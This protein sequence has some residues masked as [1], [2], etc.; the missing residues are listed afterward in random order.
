[1]PP[2]VAP[3][4]NRGSTPTSQSIGFDSPVFGLVL[5]GGGLLAVMF[6]LVP[7]LAHWRMR[8]RASLEAPDQLLIPLTHRSIWY[9]AALVMAVAV[10][11]AATQPLISAWR[12]ISL[13]LSVLAVFSVA[14]VSRR[15]WMD[16][17]GFVFLGGLTVSIAV[18]WLPMGGADGLFGL[19]LAGF[20]TFWFSQ[21]WRQ[22]L[23]NGQAWTTTGRL[24]SKA[25]RIAHFLA[26]VSL[27]YAAWLGY[28][29]KRGV[30]L[31]LIGPVAGGVTAFVL[32]GFGAALVFS[33]H[34]AGTRAGFASGV[35]SVLAALICAARTVV[36]ARTE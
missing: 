13:F 14:H 20:L 30:T 18:D 35:M 28:A 2:F 3:I 29:H 34:Q 15:G 25:A 4:V 27:G 7:V 36:D 22:Q 11:I 32:A 16:Y 10:G 19:A 6:M 1:M 24:V 9:F 26:F 8:R 17:L 21:F 23:S 5:L 33:A 12:P 31:E